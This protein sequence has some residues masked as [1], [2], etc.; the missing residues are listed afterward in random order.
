M[1]EIPSETMPQRRF[2]TESVSQPL[3]SKIYSHQ[4]GIGRLK[5]WL[6]REDFIWKCRRRKLSPS[7][8]G[9]LTKLIEQVNRRKTNFVHTGAP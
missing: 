6:V 3:K 4:K 8:L 2:S 1:Y 7:L 9:S 5:E